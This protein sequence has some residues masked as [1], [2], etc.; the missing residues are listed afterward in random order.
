[1][2]DDT[3]LR[4]ARHCTVV[5][6]A[7]RADCKG[8]VLERNCDDEHTTSR[9]GIPSCDLSR[10][11][12]RRTSAKLMRLARN[13]IVLTPRV[14]TYQRPPT[15][16]RRTSDSST[17]PHRS[18]ET[19]QYPGLVVSDGAINGQRVQITRAQTVRRPIGDRR[20]NPLLPNGGGLQEPPS[21]FLTNNF[22]R[23][24]NYALRIYVFLNRWKTHIC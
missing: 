9:A 24:Q 2:T 23:F 8:G 13:L 18:N 11:A 19:R 5:R 4:R 21:L 20:F 7:A 14:Q 12:V 15:V 16:E 6:C 17:R 22:F 3:K 10:T 1:L